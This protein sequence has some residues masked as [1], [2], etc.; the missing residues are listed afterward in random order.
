[1]TSLAKRLILTFTSVPALFILI[2]FF[3]QM[4]HLAFA[5]LVF[6][7]V[8]TGTYE[9]RNISMRKEEKPLLPFWAT[10]LLP[11]SEYIHLSFLPVLP[12]TE[13]CLFSLFLIAY[14]RE[15]KRGAYDDFEHT[16][17]RISHI[18][19]LIIYPR[20]LVVMLFLLVFGND[21]FAY[22]FGMLFG[23]NNR[24]VFKVS[25]NKS[26]AGFLGGMLMTIVLSVVW[27][28]IIPSM[29]ELFTL[30]QAALLGLII[31]L[32]SD[33]GDLIESAFKR[34]AKVKDAGKII[35]GRGGLMDSIDS[36]VASAPIFLLFVATIIG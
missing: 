2:F 26:I 18:S 30:W 19:F 9:M 20:F 32:S 10:G 35:L 28:L 4:N 25:P 23:K 31:A 29:Y 14:A 13:F 7:S 16:L 27:V 15:I 8:L 36:L 11:I 24:G 22:V 34:G 1:M 6:L 12:L 5:V 17:H 3:P 21:I 33:I